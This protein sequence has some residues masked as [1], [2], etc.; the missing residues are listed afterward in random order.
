VWSGIYARF[1]IGHKW[2]TYGDGY[3]ASAGWMRAAPPQ[4]SSTGQNGEG[5]G[6]GL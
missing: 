6:G 1:F 3:K 2:P 4:P 5:L